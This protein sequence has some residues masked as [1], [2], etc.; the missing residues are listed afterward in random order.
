MSAPRLSQLPWLLF[1]R[2][3]IELIGYSRSTI[4]KLV[5]SGTL[6]AVK[7]AGCGQ[8]RFQKIQVAQLLNVS[9]SLEPFQRAPWL[10]PE[11]AFLQY[12]GYSR[13]TLRE[14]VEAGGL[15]RIRPAG[16]AGARYYK[17]ELARLLG[18]SDWLKPG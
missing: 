11:K 4:D 6:T 5:D 7:P 9:L 1:E 8:R 15:R 17:S 13:K 10:L 3:V 16:L 2:Q 12:T 18:L 14:I